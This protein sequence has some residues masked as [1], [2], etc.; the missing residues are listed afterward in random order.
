MVIVDLY[1]EL[2]VKKKVE[3]DKKV[4][5]KEVI[6]VEEKEKEFDLLKVKERLGVLEEIVKEIVV[7]IK[8]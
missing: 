2:E 6:V 1:Q 8:K 5:E 4:K 3:E 7:E